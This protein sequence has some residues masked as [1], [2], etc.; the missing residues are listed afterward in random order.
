MLT[1]SYYHKLIRLWMPRVW[2]ENKVYSMSALTE[3][4][5]LELLSSPGFPRET[6]PRLSDGEML[7]QFYLIIRQMI[8]NVHLVL[9]VVLDNVEIKAQFLA[10]D[11]LNQIYRDLFSEVAAFEMPMTRKFMR[12]MALAKVCSLLSLSIFF[13][14]NNPCFFC[15]FI[16]SLGSAPY[17][18]NF[19]TRKK[20]QFIAIKLFSQNFNLQVSFGRSVCLS[21]HP[22]VS[23]SVS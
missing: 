2:V 9:Q 6:V 8:K 10:S 7:D 17:K 4:I 14:F 13:G 23:Q 18:T 1:M 16:T 5:D 20:L 19:E 15:F 22:S 3:T 11:V 21:V 12:E